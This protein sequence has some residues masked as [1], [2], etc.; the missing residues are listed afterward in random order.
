MVGEHRLIAVLQRDD[1]AAYIALLKE[2]SLQQIIVGFG[3]YFT[4]GFVDEPGEWLSKVG[5]GSAGQQC[6][7]DA[8][9]CPEHLIG[10]CA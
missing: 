2:E 3:H 5:G 10:W 4:G 6:T 9:F 7:K 1:F 8:R